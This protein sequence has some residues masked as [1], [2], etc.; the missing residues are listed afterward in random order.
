M[1]ASF[2]LFSSSLNCRERF[3]FI[4]KRFTSFLNWIN[5]LH[6]EIVLTKQ[7]Y[8]NRLKYHSLSLL[9]QSLGFTSI[10]FFSIKKKKCCQCWRLL[11]FPFSS[12]LSVLIVNDSLLSF[13]PLSSE[14]CVVSRMHA[15]DVPTC[16]PHNFYKVWAMLK[17][18]HISKQI[19][20]LL[21]LPLLLLELHWVVTLSC[22]HWFWLQITLW[23]SQKIIKQFLILEQF[24]K[25][26]K[27]TSN[28]CRTK[29]LN[30]VT[31]I[32]T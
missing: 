28:S 7:K 22:W 21:K 15:L 8:Q 13:I 5:S 10:I 29:V 14:S 27:G 11:T 18:L 9:H 17:A 6:L 26:L 19:Q 32:S 2:A 12:A 30:S 4:L 16:T 20:T 3:I 23:N 31:F 25:W 24:S 1:T